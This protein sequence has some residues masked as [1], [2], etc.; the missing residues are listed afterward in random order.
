MIGITT[1]RL[2]LKKPRRKDKQL[3]VSQIGDWEVSKWLSKVPYP[4]TEND[5][6]EWIRTLSR[7]NLTFNIFENDSLIGGIELAPHED[8]SHE[9]GFWLGREHWGQGFAT[10]ACKGL[11]QYAAEELNIRNFISSYMI[12]NDASARVLAK[13]GFIKSGE[14]EIYCLSR[15]ETLP[16]VNLV[17]A[18]PVLPNHFQP[19]NLSVEDADAA[20]PLEAYSWQELRGMIY[21]KPETG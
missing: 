3:I 6:N 9:L 10:E 12:G 16:C 5:A 8:N 4:Y 1:E 7:K 17:L 20:D 19:P 18:V 14:G 15:K 21:E 13:L 11:L 2:V